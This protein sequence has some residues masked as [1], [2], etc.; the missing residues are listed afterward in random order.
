MPLAEKLEV[1]EVKVKAENL[2]GWSGWSDGF[3]SIA[4]TRQQGAEAAEATLKACIEARSIDGLVRILREVQDIEFEND[5]YIVQGTELLARLQAAKERLDLAV[6]ERDPTPLR[7]ALEHA[8]QVELPGL[9]KAEAPLKKLDNVCEKLNSAK[10]IDALKTALKAAYE[11]RLPAKLLTEP[12]ERLG[13][14]EAAEF[15]LAEA[16]VAARVA[17]LAA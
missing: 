5:R 10:G 6:K 14:R 4:I 12:V 2:G 7:Q 15:G 16:I 3:E 13:T 8:T 11:A 17:P 1:H 9:G